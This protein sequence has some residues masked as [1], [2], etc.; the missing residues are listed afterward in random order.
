MSKSRSQIEKFPCPSCKRSFE[1]AKLLT[2]VEQG[3]CKQR[4]NDCLTKLLRRAN[5]RTP[6]AQV[7]KTGLQEILGGAEVS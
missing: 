3:R 1:L 6:A 5:H 2:H 7:L 4:A